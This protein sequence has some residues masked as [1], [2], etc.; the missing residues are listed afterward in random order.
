MLNL[1]KKTFNNLIIYALSFIILILLAPQIYEQYLAEPL[2][3]QIDE[4]TLLSPSKQPISPFN[5]N[6]SN[7]TP[8]TQENFLD[9]W[10]LIFIGYTHC[11]DVCPF[12]LKIVGDMLKRT[13]K[14]DMLESPTVY[15]ISV[16]PERD[17]LEHLASYTQFFHPDILG[18]T[19][20]VSQLDELSLQLGTLYEMED[21]EESPEDYLVSHSAQLFLIAPNGH[22]YAQF[23]PPH[24]AATLAND[25]AK[26]RRYYE[27]FPNYTVD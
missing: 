21:N 6:L 1:P 12:T 3:P 26:L 9:Q 22:I 19:G 20:K 4:R 10:S 7:G 23:F 25:Y 8:L 14:N 5:L 16:D 27:A 18:A 24:D 15:F 17:T 2:P 13:D 11:P